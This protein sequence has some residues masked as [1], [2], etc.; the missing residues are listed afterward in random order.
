MTIVKISYSVFL[1]DVP[2]EVAK[3]ARDLQKEFDSLSKNIDTI[4]NELEENPKDVR[5][6]IAKLDHSLKLAE[7][8]S[9]KLKDCQAILDGYSKVSDPNFKMPEKKQ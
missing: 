8:L 6:P 4:C 9:S 1:E 3:L 7:K 5:T 2:M